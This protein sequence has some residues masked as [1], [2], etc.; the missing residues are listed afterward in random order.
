MTIK[1]CEVTRMASWNYY[2][3]KYSYLHPRFSDIEHSRRFIFKRNRNGNLSERPARFREG[4]GAAEYGGTKEEDETNSHSLFFFCFHFFQQER[5]FYFA[6]SRNT[7]YSWKMRLQR[8]QASP[9]LLSSPPPPFRP[10]RAFTESLSL[11]I[12]PCNTFDSHPPSTSHDQHHKSSPDRAF[13][14]LP[15]P[16]CR[17]R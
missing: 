6:L 17:A 10:S 15:P 9:P 1:L 13:R 4:P 11:A 12:A 7:S 14:L 8:P 3:I 5:T 16:E 2:D